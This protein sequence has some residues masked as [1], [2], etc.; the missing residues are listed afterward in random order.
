MHEHGIRLLVALTLVFRSV[1]VLD[2]AG[3]Q[4]RLLALEHTR[5]DVVHP[6][7]LLGGLDEHG[8]FDPL[9]DE[10]A[11]AKADLEQVQQVPLAHRAAVFRVADVLVRVLGRP[12]VGRVAHHRLQRHGVGLRHLLV[13]E[14]RVA[15]SREHRVDSDKRAAGIVARL[16]S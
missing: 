15:I 4:L 3:L 12:I 11:G 6:G 8:A 9:E 7:G 2:S 16:S 14:R 5:D 13:S 10:V 1:A